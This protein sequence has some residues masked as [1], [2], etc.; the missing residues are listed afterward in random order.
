MKA[1]IGIDPVNGESAPRPRP[2]RA[3]LAAGLSIL[4]L[5]AALPLPTAALPGAGD[6]VAVLLSK[7][8]Q[9]YKVTCRY[10]AEGPRMILIG[11]TDAKGVGKRVSRRT[12][13]AGSGSY[14]WTGK[15]QR[16]G[17]LVRVCAAMHSLEADQPTTAYDCK[18]Y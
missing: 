7:T 5:F 14:T 4:L 1:A 16:F 15:R 3:V 17:R 2:W 10:T 13:K 18:Y 6:E 11:V 9:V 12:V 8:D